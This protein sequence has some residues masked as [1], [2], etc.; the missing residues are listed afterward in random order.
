[1]APDASRPG[2]PSVASE[3]ETSGSR[4][5]S[6][7]ETAA[8]LAGVD[9]VCPLPAYICP[10]I[11]PAGFAEDGSLKAEPGADAACPGS[12]GAVELRQDCDGWPFVPGDAANAGATITTTAAATIAA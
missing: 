4:P 1:A 7:C 2:R 11:P 3:A 12:I 8:P 6:Y 5:T 9:V 10:A